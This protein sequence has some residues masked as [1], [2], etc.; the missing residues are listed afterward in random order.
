MTKNANANAKPSA[1]TD[2]AL[3]KPAMPTK[4]QQIIEMLSREGGASLDYIHRSIEGAEVYFVVNRSDR[5]ERAE[6]GFRVSG[7][8]PEIW[9]PV[10]GE[11]RAA[12]ALVPD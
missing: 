7:K 9:D 11:T 8:Q 2:V 6:C 10:T 1:D 3:P 12:Q 5:E 4:H